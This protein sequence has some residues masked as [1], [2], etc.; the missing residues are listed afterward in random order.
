LQQEG[1][2]VVELR[3]VPP[4]SAS[5][6][7]H[8]DGVGA[9]KNGLQAIG[10]SRDGWSTKI[11][12]VAANDVHAVGFRLLPGQHGDGPK[13][14]ELSGEPGC[15]AAGCALV[16]D[17]AYESDETLGLA[18]LLGFT[19]GVTGIYGS[20]FSRRVNLADTWTMLRCQRSHR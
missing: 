16:G 3:V 7:G 5:V 15:P 13:G 19:P 4:D 14:R 1:V 11:H 2:L 6:K 10:K 20:R 12:L 17:M 9:G 18:N 8:P